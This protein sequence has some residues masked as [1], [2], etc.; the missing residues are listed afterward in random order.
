M[1]RWWSGCRSWYIVG[2][3]V[4]PYRGKTVQHAI[5][6][7]PINQPPNCPLA[8]GPSTGSLSHGVCSAVKLCQKNRCW[9]QVEYIG[10]EIGRA[11]IPPFP[12]VNVRWQKKRLLPENLQ[13]AREPF[14]L[15]NSH[16]E[17]IWFVQNSE[18]LY[19]FGMLYFAF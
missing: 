18:V 4:L 2:L 11:L 17:K 6:Q 3:F 7:H 1:S 15:S 12:H 9:P 8:P 5:R 16:W 14:E 13:T 10:D 19:E